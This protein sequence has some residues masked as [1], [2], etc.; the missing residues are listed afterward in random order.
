M[1]YAPK[2]EWDIDTCFLLDSSGC[3]P[4]LAGKSLPPMKA[5]KRHSNLITKLSDTT[6][7][8]LCM[9]YALQDAQRATPQN[10][11]TE[12]VEQLSNTIQSAERLNE[13][14]FSSDPT[15]VA[16]T[17]YELGLLIGLAQGEVDAAYRYGRDRK[18]KSEG[19]KKSA[20]RS[21]YREH[22]NILLRHLCFKYLGIHRN[23]YE[24]SDAFNEETD[25]DMPSQSFRGYYSKF[26]NGEPLWKDST[27]RFP[28]SEGRLELILQAL[29]KCRDN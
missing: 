21:T 10:I 19:G 28:Q 8:A 20:K 23:H 7:L 22:E 4:S 11:A 25:L 1:C 13:N 2:K 6:S 24:A 5:I 16:G 18:A 17:F 15:L 14:M 29:G 12:L 26:M 27:F 3:S 9:I